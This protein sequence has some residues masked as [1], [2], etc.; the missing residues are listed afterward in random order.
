MEQLVRTACRKRVVESKHLH[1][2]YSTIRLRQ[3][4]LTRISI[5]NLL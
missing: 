2:R 5:A 3:M 1:D 4:V